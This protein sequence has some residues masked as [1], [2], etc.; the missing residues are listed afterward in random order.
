MARRLEE[1]FDG[2]LLVRASPH[3]PGLV[4][5]VR[6]MAR[7]CGV[8]SFVATPTIERLVEQIGPADHLIFVL[9]DGL[10]MNLLEQ[11]PANG[12]IRRHTTGELQATFPSTTAVALT[13]VATG[14]WPAQHGITGWHTHAPELGLTATVLPFVER[15][16]EQPLTQRGLIAEHLMPMAAFYPLMD[17]PS[18]T[19][20]PA[21]IAH[22][23]YATWSRGHTAGLGYRSIA[24]AVDQV[25]THVRGQ[26]GASYAHLY[27][28][29]IDSLCHK[30]GTRHASVQK[31]LTSIDEQMQRLAD[32]VDG[33]RMV[34]S[35]DHGL[36][37]VPL[38]R[39]IA[40]EFD[41]PLV[42]LLQVPPSGDARLP[43]FHVREGK[44]RQFVG[45]FSERFGEDLL[46]LESEVAG[47]MELFGP[48]PMSEVGRRRFGDYVAIPTS[49]VSLHYRPPPP[50]KAG[51]REPFLAQHAGLTAEE[52]LVPLVVC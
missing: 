28:P 29:H 37:D 13:S 43:I 48:A 39:H 32:E 3:Q 5:L 23:V 18:L 33:A 22:T 27:I 51:P 9:L 2:G 8:K 7:I 36:I 17:R 40:L 35:A 24:E 41:D 46:L 45:Q 25:V 52:M 49:T 4:P 30:V 44:R 38:E 20:L 14:E 21:E 16:T 47:G 15:F 11:L 6:A 31:L 12:F 26:S 19:L 50:Y 1:L 42:H 34:L 10:G